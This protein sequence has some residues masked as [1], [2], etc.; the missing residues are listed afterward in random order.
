MFQNKVLFIGLVWPE[1]TSSAAGKR[2]LQLVEFFCHQG[3]EVSF[4]SAAAKSDSS[5]DFSAE[6]QFQSVKEV[7]IQLNHSSFDEFIQ[8]LQPDWVIYDRFVSEEQFGWRVHQHCPNAIQILDTEDLHLLRF[9]REKAYKS[10]S[11]VDY[12]NEIAQREI[13]SILR[14]DLSLMI[15]KVEIDL[16]EDL[17]QI[18]TTHL[19]YLPF[20]EKIK[21]DYQIKTFDD[22][23][24]FVFIGNFLHEPNWQTVLK[25][26]KEIWPL[27]R[28][29]LKNAQLHIYGAYPSQKVWDLHKAEQGFLIH[30]KADDSLEVISKSRVLLA[31]IPF[32]AGQKG[33]FIDAMQTGTPFVSSSIGVEAMFDGEIPGLVSDE[34]TE[35]ARLAV[36]LYQDENQ[37]NQL[38]QS[39]KPI[40]KS[41]FDAEL[42]LAEFSKRLEE[43]SSDLKQHRN[44]NF[45]GQI[46]KT[47][48]L[49]ALKYMSLWIET[50][51]A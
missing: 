31:P 4:A 42:Y 20:L 44:R 35:F 28:T 29:Q 26:K 36:S 24:D 8:N 47:N 45:I 15:S 1:P 48:T 10:N 7:A 32:G 34:P 50:K 37:W 51:N 43:I 23:K 11:D 46:L 25:L 13:A 17:F 39:A 27:I 5:F 30:G 12:F 3:C 19:F 38:S 49:N 18:P 22:R 6:A 9:A 14:C 40:L 41:Q 21:S 33:K 16:L 2:I